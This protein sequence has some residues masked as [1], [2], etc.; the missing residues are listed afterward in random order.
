[1]R[2]A[3]PKMRGGGKSRNGPGVTTENFVRD[4]ES[5]LIYRYCQWP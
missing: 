2:R 4:L 5:F 1:M 3:I